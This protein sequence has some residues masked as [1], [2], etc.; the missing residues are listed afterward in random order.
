MNYFRKMS[1]TTKISPM[2]SL[3]EIMC[4]WIGAFFGI[5]TV[6]FLHYHILNT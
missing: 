5:A 4:S 6:A 2:V 1:G 3:T